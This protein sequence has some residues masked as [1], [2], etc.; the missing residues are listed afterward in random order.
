MQP[1]Y[2]CRTDRRRAFSE[3]V[4]AIAR[5]CRVARYLVLIVVGF[6]VPTIAVIGYLLMALFFLIPIALAAAGALRESALA[7]QA[8]PRSA[9]LPEERAHVADDRSGC[10]IAWKRPA[11]R[12]L[13]PVPDCRAG[14]SSV[15]T[16]GSAPK[17]AKPTGAGPARSTP[18]RHA[19]Q[20][21]ER[22]PRRSG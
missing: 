4:F 16:N 22:R 17:T 3:G 13:G 9:G 5:R 18:G 10:S 2:G 7:A 1:R 8:V 11:D 21:R 6:I 12:E 15:R 20:R 14:S 19:V